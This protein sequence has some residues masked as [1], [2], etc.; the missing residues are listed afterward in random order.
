MVDLEIRCIENALMSYAYFQ[1]NL[2]NILAD[3]SFQI[4]YFTISKL[5]FEVPDNGLIYRD[6]DRSPILTIRLFG[7][8]TTFIGTFELSSEFSF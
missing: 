2:Q 6:G 7:H 5:L 3:L 4:F 1:N 8:L